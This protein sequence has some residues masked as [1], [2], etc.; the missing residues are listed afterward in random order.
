MRELGVIS[1]VDTPTDWANSTAL[2]ESTN[3]KG[4]ITKLRVFL[5]PRDL[6]KW[7]KREQHYTKTIDEVVTQLSD[8]KF[9][10]LVDA[11]KGY[12]HVP[13]DEPS[14]YLTTFGTPFGRFRF[15]WLPYGLIASQD[16]SQKQL[17]AALEGLSG[18][19]GIADDTYT[20][21]STDQEYGM[22]LANLMERA[23]Q[24]GI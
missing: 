18:V 5:D 15:T 9:F 16:V 13:L 1:R 10:T 20:F 2:S 6:N 22:N 4:E 14:S 8:A 12:W 21:G 17:D 7:I 23:R 11:R 3:D 19:R 24:K